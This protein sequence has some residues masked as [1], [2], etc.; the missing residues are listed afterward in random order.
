[1]DFVREWRSASDLYETVSA[2]PNFARSSC[3]S[4]TSDATSAPVIAAASRL[5]LSGGRGA[6]EIGEPRGG[7]M[8][9][10]RGGGEG[11]PGG[12]GRAEPAAGEREGRR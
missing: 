4:V 8:G 5:R 3:S 2:T 1:M 6:G 7:E 9:E 10:P 11:D 12:G